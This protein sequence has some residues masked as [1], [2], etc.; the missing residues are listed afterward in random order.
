MAAS[1]AP[2]DIAGVVRRWSARTP[3]AVMLHL[4]DVEVTWREC[5]AR[6][7]R[8]AQGLAAEG[9]GKQ[10]RVAFLGRNSLEWFAVLFGTAKLNGVHVPV[11]WRLAPPEVAYALHD[12]EVAV[13]FVDPEFLPL[14]AGIEAAVPSLRRVVVL[15]PRSGI[16]TGFEDWLE[17]R[18]ASDP[19]AECGAEDVAMLLY[20]SGTTGSPK[21]VMLTYK[22][23][24][25]LRELA[26][27]LGVDG[28]AVVLVAMPVFH[29]AGSGWALLGLDAGGKDVVLP[30]VTAAGVIEAVT[31]HRTTHALLVPTVI[32]LMLETPGI[33][34]A[35]MT[36]LRCLAYG[37]S[38]ISETILRRALA[39]LDVGLT[40]LYGLTETTGGITI[41]RPADHDPD[42]P[43][44][45][46]SCGRPLP[47]I[48]VRVVSTDGTGDAPDGVVGELW[49]R[50]CQVMKGYWRNPA[51]TATVL[52]E[53]GWLRT[54][55]AGTADAEGYL[56][57]HDRL[58]D[59]VVS[60]G[61]N[62]VP[63]EVE[64]VLMAHEAVADAAVIGVPHEKWGETPKAIVVRK[65]GTMVD[66]VALIAFARERLAH[67]KC[68][69]SVD[70]VDELP[71]N[72]SG[73]VLK[74]ELRRPFWDGHGRAIG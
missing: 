48:E 46:R 47:G 20:T 23:L 29:I 70:F 67:Y 58:K 64:N 72:P 27:V 32:R 38:P 26:V 55:D 37:S 57:L 21:G 52:T 10:D 9:V 4:G 14:I 1:P 62:I 7:N 6:S 19:G 60:G 28:S 34:H 49:V 24:T 22:N 74:R 59:I 66:G 50:A 36:C 56:Y 63:A 44:L 54:G 73:K 65:P 71:R 17:G 43:G 39:T 11:N 41:L 31:R 61:E 25:A 30:E 51:A 16:W 68:P 33:E 35:D 45:L 13:L 69:T 3:D 15:G 53:D 12:A 8:V 18:A 40:Q 42:R 5:D 2:F